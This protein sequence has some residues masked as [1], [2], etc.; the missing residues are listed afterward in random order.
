MC[1]S[2]KRTVA[3]FVSVCQLEPTIK[4]IYVEGLSDVLVINRFLRKRK[5]NNVTV[6]AI[7]TIDF[8]DVLSNMSTTESQIIKG[9]NKEKV[10]LLAQEV[11]KEVKQCPFLAIIDR[12]LDFVNNHVKKGR[13]LSY[14]DYNSMDMYLYS[15]Y[16]VDA[17]LT[18]SFRITSKFNVDNFL[19]SIGS[20]CRTLFHIRAYLESSDGAMVDV[21]KCLSYD[22]KNNTCVFDMTKY[23][24]KII[25]ANNIKESSEELRKQIEEKAKAPIVDT[26]LEIKGHDF[27]KILYLSICK[28]KKVYMS[29][30]EMAN[31]FLVYL[32]DSLLANEPLFK[33]ICKL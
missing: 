28:H 7:E 31:S 15:Q 5:I 17:L 6:Y 30:E 3:E 27:I 10:V 23:I 25:Q 32:E 9:N 24:T 20:V 1:G 16:Y 12:D 11:E 18:N 8:E 2:F 22:K 14:T 29:E 21:K 4:N 13:Y 33:R 19:S 26:R